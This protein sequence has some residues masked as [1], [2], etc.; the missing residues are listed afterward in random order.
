LCGGV[1][2][3]ATMMRRLRSGAAGPGETGETAR[4]WAG[5]GAKQGR[6]GDVRRPR[7]R[8]GTASVEAAGGGMGGVGGGGDGVDVR[9]RR[10]GGDDD[11]QAPVRSCRAGRDR[12]EGPHPDRLGCEAPQIDLN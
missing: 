11:A 10:C 8:R 1:D 4:N 5:Q 3:A 9:R 6:P 7:A 2:A 12:R